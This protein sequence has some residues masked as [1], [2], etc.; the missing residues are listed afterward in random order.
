MEIGD[1]L[2]FL[3]YCKDVY[4]IVAQ[5]KKSTGEFVGFVKTGTAKANNTSLYADTI[6][7]Y[8]KYVVTIS[9]KLSGDN[10]TVSLFNPTDKS[11]TVV[12]SISVPWLQ[13][14]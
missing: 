9:N 1:N 4:T 10:I 3:L 12:T 2:Y 8:N 14:V 7:L 11:F 6:V 5:Y 13:G